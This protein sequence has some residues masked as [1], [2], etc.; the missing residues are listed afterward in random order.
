MTLTLISNRFRTNTRLTAADRLPLRQ[1]GVDMNRATV[2]TL[3]QALIDLGLPMPI[4]TDRGRKPPDGIFGSEMKATVVAFQRSRVPPLDDDGEIGVNTM[5]A[6]DAAIDRFDRRGTTPTGTFTVAPFSVPK[7]VL[8]GGGCGRVGA[9]DL[10][11]GDHPVIVDPRAA[12]NAGHA[13]ALLGLPMGGVAALMAAV[14]AGF[15]ALGSDGRAVVA[16]FHAGSGTSLTHLNGSAVSDEMKRSTAFTTF[17]ATIKAGI[18]SSLAA[19]VPSHTVD[20]RRITVPDPGLNF[21]N[22]GGSLPGLLAIVA[23]AP[24]GSVGHANAEMFILVG[25]TQGRKATLTAFSVAPGTRNY[26]ARLHFE[27]CDHFGVDESDLRAAPAVGTRTIRIPVPFGSPITRT[28][29]VPHP[30]ACFW[31]LQHEV[32]GGPGTSHVA[33]VLSIEANVDISGTF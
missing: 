10:R 26:T 18:E 11:S 9:T 24:A 29:S 5:P 7:V 32:S 22:P 17:V 30:L 2:A 27:I 19:A 13:R 31:V 14:D 1:G 3:Q 8:A 28:I 25:G 23:T 15:F 33:F 4:T 6:L 20:Y 16:H 21:P 12:T